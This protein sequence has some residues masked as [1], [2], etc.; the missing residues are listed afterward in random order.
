MLKLKILSQNYCKCHFPNTLKTTKLW[1]KL[2]KKKKKSGTT[3]IEDKNLKNDLISVVG[4]IWLLSLAVVEILE[5]RRKIEPQIKIW[6]KLYLKTIRRKT[7]ILLNSLGQ[8]K[9]A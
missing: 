9:M 8:K 6:P 2:E 5:I 4:L 1:K 3:K 7:T